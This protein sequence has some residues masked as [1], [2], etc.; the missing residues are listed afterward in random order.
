MLM[1]KHFIYIYIRL[2][3]LSS[4]FRFFIKFF[5]LVEIE[6]QALPRHHAF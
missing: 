2:S 4:L 6:L 1:S 3:I 5:I